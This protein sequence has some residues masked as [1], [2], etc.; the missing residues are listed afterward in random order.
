MTDIRQQQVPRQA[1]H[2]VQTT[3]HQS[4]QALIELFQQARTQSYCSLILGVAGIICFAVFGTLA[5][6]ARFKDS[7]AIYYAFYYLPYALIGLSIPITLYHV[8]LM[9]RYRII[10]ANILLIMLSFGLLLPLV[11]LIKYVNGDGIQ[12]AMAVFLA[13][14]AWFSM[15]YLLKVNIIRFLNFLTQGNSDDNKQSKRKHPKHK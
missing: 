14:V 12:A 10:Q 5:S 3:H 13:M 2:Q 7:E 4:S 8:F 11:A 15:P 1:K 6:M 9:Y